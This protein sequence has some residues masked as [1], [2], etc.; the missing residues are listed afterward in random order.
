MKLICSVCGRPLTFKALCDA[1]SKSI[2]THVK[3][4]VSIWGLELFTFE[5]NL[6]QHI[7]VF[8]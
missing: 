4:I 5:S 7:H 6:L 3:K 8:H 2:K 1:C